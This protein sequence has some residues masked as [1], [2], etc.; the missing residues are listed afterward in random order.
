MCPNEA[1]E[2]LIPRV[3]RRTVP[4]D[5]LQLC[6]AKRRELTVR[7]GE[8]QVTF[9]GKQYHYRL[10][11]NRMGLLGLNGRKVELAYDPF[12]LGKGA[13][14]Y[15][16]ALWA[17]LSACHCGEWA[18]ARSCRMSGIGGMHAAR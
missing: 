13:V 3:E 14:Y 6:F 9:A 1:W 4:E 18:K 16:S 11:D 12:D 2:I 10:T 15:E 5:V 17:W 8:V 7:N